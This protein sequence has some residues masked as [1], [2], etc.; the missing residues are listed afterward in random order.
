MR[1]QTVLCYR[2]T[3]N[4]IFKIK[5]IIYSLRF[6]TLQIKTKNVGARLEQTQISTHSWKEFRTT[7]SVLESQK[8][9]QP[10]DQRP[11]MVDLQT[12]VSCGSMMDRIKRL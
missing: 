11:L 12:D 10:F 4:M 5:Q 9:V 3:Y 2:Y 8:A 7:V 1:L 6:S